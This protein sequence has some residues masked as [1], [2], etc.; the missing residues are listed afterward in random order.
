MGRAT[1]TNIV[2][3]K[4][5]QRN[6]SARIDSRRVAT[7]LEGRQAPE[8]TKPASGG[9]CCPARSWESQSCGK[10]E[11]PK[12]VIGK[13]GRHLH[14]FELKNAADHGSPSVLARDWNQAL[15]NSVCSVS[16]NEQNPA[17]VCEHGR[18]RL[19]APIDSGFA[20]PCSPVAGC[21]RRQCAAISLR[22]QIQTRSWR[23]M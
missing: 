9:P 2:F 4:G 21:W 10:R 23:R 6:S 18:R 7:V 3:S 14:T 20:H 1:I 15:T 22:R 8:T 13:R 12:I 11:V 16:P 17:I 19:Q 5:G